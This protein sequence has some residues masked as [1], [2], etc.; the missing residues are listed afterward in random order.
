[1]TM[2][3]IVLL[4]ASI[5]LIIVKIVDMR[6][7]EIS[8][9]M[10][11][12]NIQLNPLNT[13]KPLNTLNPLNP[14]KPDQTAGAVV[15]NDPNKKDTGT[16]D[17]TV[18][19]SNIQSLPQECKDR[20]RF[21]AKRYESPKDARVNTGVTPP[22][23]HDH[24]SRPAPWIRAKPALESFPDPVQ[25]AQYGA[26]RTFYMDPKNMTPE[27]VQKFKLKA[28]FEKM[29]VD[30][31]TNWLNLFSDAPQQLTP[32]HRA[33]LRI[34]ARGGKLTRSDMP[35]YA[36]IP[37]QSNQEYLDKISRGDMNKNI[38][39]PEYAGYLPYN[40]DQAIETNIDSTR[41]LRHMDFIN[42]DEPLKVW[43][44]TYKPFKLKQG[45][46]KG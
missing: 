23:S 44:L 28:K 5:G 10:P 31:Y 42:P 27:Q 37:S 41:D 38:P 35:A 17:K 25:P 45:D 14:V 33:N 19:L 21:I 2:A 7:S 24:E 15:S 30:D 36:P 22:P 9:N 13:L 12:I 46:V 32:F 26:G 40:I 39:Q 11:A 4:A 16:I 29:T 20:T 18:K 8:I 3:V 6:L 34:I 43:E 1:M